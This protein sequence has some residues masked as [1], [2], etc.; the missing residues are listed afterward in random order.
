LPRKR[1]GGFRGAGECQ[2]IGEAGASGTSLFP[3]LHYQLATR[4]GLDGEGL[5]VRFDE[6]TRIIGATK[7]PEDDAWIDSGD[8]VVTGTDVGYPY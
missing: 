3:H 5:P 4:P 7:K 8:I 2:Q 6:V 1:S